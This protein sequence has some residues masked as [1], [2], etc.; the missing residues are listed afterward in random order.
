LSSRNRKKKERRNEEEGVVRRGEERWARSS[1]CEA[2]R[3]QA[4][5][6]ADHPGY[7]IIH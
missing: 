6:P 1:G 5:N 2:T 7:A 3:Q 4:F